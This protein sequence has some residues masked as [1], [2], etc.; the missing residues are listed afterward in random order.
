MV[1][2]VGPRHILVDWVR[3]QHT[4]AEQ[5]VFEPE[6]LTIIERVEFD[7]L[8]QEVH[9]LDVADGGDSAVDE[10]FEDLG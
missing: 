8:A 5:S 1:I 2:S 10:R 7:R 9:E 6:W 3:R 4:L